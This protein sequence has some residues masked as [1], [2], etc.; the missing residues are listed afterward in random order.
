MPVRRGEALAIALSDSVTIAGR[1]VWWDGERCGVAFDAPIDCAA[2]LDGSG[3]RAERAALPAAA[4]AGLDPAIAYCEK[5]LHSVR[6]HDLSQHG[7][8]FSHDGCFRAG[9][10]AKLAFATGDEHRGVV[11]GRRTAAPSCLLTEPIPCARLESAA[12]L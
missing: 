10:A 12:R 3:R 8:G 1:V 6:L 5:G 7:A 2:L 11:R 4:A 9:M